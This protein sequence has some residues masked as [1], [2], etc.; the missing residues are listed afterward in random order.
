MPKARK[1]PSG[2][3]RCQPSF[4]DEYGVQHRASFTESTRAA[5]E[6]KAVLWQEGLIEAKQMKLMHPF[7]TAAEEYIETLR[8]TGA[9]PSTIRSYCS[10]MNTAYE[11]LLDKPIN[12]ITLRDIQQWVN[13]RAATSAPKTV[14]NNLGFISAV[15]RAN[16]C[17]LDL[18]SLKMPKR[19]RQEVEIPDDAQVAAMLD[20][21]YDDDNMYI[22][23]ALA[24]LMGLRRSEI[25]AL[26]W[27]DVVIDA[28]GIARLN[29]DKALVMD[30]NGRHVEKDPKTMA[31]SR[32]LVIPDAL[33]LELK[34][35]RNL[36]P[37]MVNITPNQLTERYAGIHKRFDAPPR[38]HS[39]R[40]YHA[41]VMLRE[42][43]PEKY[44]VADMGHATF[45]MVRR[46]YGHV[47]GEKK[48]VINQ[49]MAAHAYDVLSNAHE[50][51]T[52]SQKI[53]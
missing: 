51:H 36:R 35:R 44:I 34:R 24:A 39:L 18:A 49:A 11:S 8:V 2:K 40:H 52:K 14:K 3:W 1:L 20:S 5:A 10:Y 12:R 28:D 21:V 46:V 45:D 25:C 27:S 17:K 13:A 30:E 29:V 53:Q 31:G 37:N 47:M 43:V 9:S 7:K 15:L 32:Q 48:G 6:R 42:G 33:Y 23:I 4:T 22:A 50:M 41:S 38:F 19:Q 26:K 16:E